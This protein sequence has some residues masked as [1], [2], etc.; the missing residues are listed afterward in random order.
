[1]KPEKP[2][3]AVLA[4]GTARSM[5][6]REISG[7]VHSRRAPTLRGKAVLAATMIRCDREERLHSAIEC[8]DCPRFVNY[9]PSEDRYYVTIRC[10]WGV[11]P[12][13]EE[14]PPEEPPETSHTP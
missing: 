5:A 4:R 9:R 12:P 14:P 8:L 1:M 11:E 3:G 10:E 7:P 13:A 2:K 6:V